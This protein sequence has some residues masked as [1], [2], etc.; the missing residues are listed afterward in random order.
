VPETFLADQ[1]E[2]Q[3]SILGLAETVSNDREESYIMANTD[4]YDVPLFEIPVNAHT[5]D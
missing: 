1:G 5:F 2:S 4:E 3:Q